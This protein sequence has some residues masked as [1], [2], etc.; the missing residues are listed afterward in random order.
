MLAARICPMST[1]FSTRLYI[2]SIFPKKSKSAVRKVHSE[3]E[4]WTLSATETIHLF[5][6]L[7]FLHDNTY[8]INCLEPNLHLCDSLFHFMSVDSLASAQY[9]LL[10]QIAVTML[11]NS[12][13]SYIMIGVLKTALCR[14]MRLPRM[15]LNKSSKRGAWQSE[16]ERLR[17]RALDKLKLNERTNRHKIQF[18]NIKE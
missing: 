13:H 3:S 8:D 11:R 6:S 10:I 15:L 18:V 14:A 12:V 2:L 4:S 17:S 5:F 9:L 7:C 16:P 1:S